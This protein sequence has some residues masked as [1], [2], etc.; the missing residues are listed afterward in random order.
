[1]KKKVKKKVVFPLEVLFFQTFKT[2]IEIHKQTLLEKEAMQSKLNI[3]ATNKNKSFIITMLYTKKK[4]Y[5][6]VFKINSF[7]NFHEESIHLYLFERM[8]MNSFAILQLFFKMYIRVHW[9]Q[10]ITFLSCWLF[11]LLEIMLQK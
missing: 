2:R 5:C 4:V 6:C 8:R 11:S 7:R 9:L 1:M 10:K 3:S